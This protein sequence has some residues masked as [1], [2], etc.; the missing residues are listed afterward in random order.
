MTDATA[1]LINSIETGNDAALN[2]ILNNEITVDYKCAL[3]NFK[4]VDIPDI[5]ILSIAILNKSYNICELLINKGA[6]LNLPD[7][8]KKTPVF[9]AC[10]CGESSILKQMLKKNSKLF[11]YYSAN[12]H[13]DESVMHPLFAA[14]NNAHYDCVEVLLDNGVDANT[15]DGN[16][17]TGLMKSAMNGY[18][19]LMD[20]FMCKG[21][22]VE[23]TDIFGRNM[24]HYIAWFGRIDC[25]NMNFQRAVYN[26]QDYL[27]MTPLHIACLHK[28]KDLIRY[29]VFGGTDLSME[30]KTGKTAEEISLEARHTSAGRI[31]EEGKLNNLTA[32]AG[33]SITELDYRTQFETMKKYATNLKQKS[34]ERTNM[35]K[36]LEEHVVVFGKMILD[37]KKLQNNMEIAYDQLNRLVTRKCIICM[38]SSGPIKCENC[39]SRFCNSCYEAAKRSCLVCARLR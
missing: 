37:M 27:G 36:E 25:S 24:L 23:Q 4:S 39:D 5:P 13:Y 31:F 15:S 9:Y 12:G 1:L 19:E 6:N 11:E 22:N 21:A 38:K 3:Y 8:Y 26:T 29:L 20:L 14:V 32:S 10:F 30:D 17:M 28:R 18:T 2:E 34:H 7:R 33:D 16:G 35:I